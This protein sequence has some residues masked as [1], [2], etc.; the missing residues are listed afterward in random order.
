MINV[1]ENHL[2]SSKYIDSYWL[3][4]II[5]DQEKNKEYLNNKYEEEIKLDF[6]EFNE[7]TENN[8]NTTKQKEKNYSESCRKY[9]IHNSYDSKKDFTGN[10]QK[11]DSFVK[12]NRYEKKD[13][14]DKQY[15]KDIYDMQSKP[16]IYE[17][18][19]KNKKCDIFSTDRET[20][21]LIKSFSR[22]NL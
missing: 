1:I 19:S 12:T 8:K 13:I 9:Y 3:N 10:Y 7:K 14:Y 22:N 4:N 15:K 6:T 11:R 5:L 16:R 17:Y 21:I 20:N 18:M 2:E